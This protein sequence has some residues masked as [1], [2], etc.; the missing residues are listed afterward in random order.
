[1]LAARITAPRAL[2]LGNNW[3]TVSPFSRICS[4]HIVSSLLESVK[5]GARRIGAHG[6]SIRSLLFTHIAV[7]APG[8]S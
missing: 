4:G 2:W 7:R 1:M 5:T 3:D 8:R 6:W